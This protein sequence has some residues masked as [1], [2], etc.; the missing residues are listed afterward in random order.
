MYYILILIISL[1]IPCKSIAAVEAAADGTV[2]GNTEGLARVEALET[3]LAN[4]TI[5][6]THPRIHVTPDMVTTMRSRATG[7]NA[8]WTEIL[9][10]ASGPTNIIDAAC[11]A[12]VLEISHPSAAATHA[13]NVYDRI[14]ASAA[15]DQLSVSHW[16]LGFDWAY[17][18]LTPPQRT[19]IANKIS[20][21]MKW[22]AGTGGTAAPSTSLPTAYAWAS[23]GGKRYDETFY[24]QTWDSGQTYAWPAIALA[25]FS[26][27]EYLAANGREMGNDA[28]YIYKALWTYDSLHG[29][30]LR[31]YAYTNDYVPTEGYFI[32]AM[33]IPWFMDLRAAT[34][35]TASPIDVVYGQDGSYG[36]NVADYQLYA[37]DSDP[38]YNR[39]VFHKGHSPQGAGGVMT[40]NDTY[41]YGA[42]GTDFN[43]KLNAQHM[44][45]FLIGAQTNPYHNWMAKNALNSYSTSGGTHL[46]AYATYDETAAYKNVVDLMYKD[47]GLP[48]SDPKTATYAQLP[49]AKKFSGAKEVYMRSSFG[50]DSVIAC[51]RTSPHLT[52]TSH[53][54]WDT[55]T[56]LIY[57]KGNLAMDSGVYDDGLGEHNLQTNSIG[58]QRN[59]VAHNNILVVDP[60][61]P[62][63]PLKLPMTGYIYGTPDPGGIDRIWS[64]TF[65][66]PNLG[67]TYLH[68]AQT[69]GGS[70]PIFETREGFDHTVTTSI[71]YGSRVSEMTRAATFIRKPNDTAYFI[72]FDRI[73]A[74]SSAFNKKWLIHGVNEF[75]DLGSVAST[76]VASH[77]VNYSGN[78]FK[79]TNT[80]QRN[81]AGTA[82]NNS[83]IYGSVLLPT[84]PNLRK[85]GG[86]F[87]SGYEFWVDGSSPRNWPLELPYQATDSYG[88][89]TWFMGGPLT[90]T[91]DGLKEAG[92]W[93]LEL[94]NVSPTQRDH[95]LVVMYVG[96]DDATAAESVLLSVTEATRAVVH[97]KDATKNEI[98]ALNKGVLGTSVD[99][100][101]YSYTPTTSSTEHILTEIAAGSS[102]VVTIG[103]AE[104]SGS[105]F[106][107]SSQGVVSFSTTDSIGSA[108]LI[109]VTSLEGTGGLIN[110]HI[111]HKPGNAAVTLKAGNTPVT[112]Q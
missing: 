14:V 80:L 38:A 29:D 45:G 58:Y 9:S 69:E 2:Y 53:G 83:A 68:N 87:G 91:I 55:N 109:V 77:I 34:Y 24:K 46:F 40:Y 18:S 19:A 112:I 27:P 73:N 104:V 76:E 20:T 89:K 105:P 1:L 4:L 23:S 82:Y 3:K 30:I 28:A 106:T 93:R 85:V 95:F 97:I 17:N 64:K 16:A 98:V 51:L 60:A 86:N 6:S 15:T 11:A 103:G 107:A 25:G 7:G 62:D 10:A 81:G 70:I 75:T 48:S 41:S 66:A 72:I 100:F 101:S 63:T 88:G 90:G 44:P 56:F 92:N 61:S 39:T 21:N 96:D 36:A 33:G 31:Y 84:N 67:L 59:T 78:T 35:G 5:K 37:W 32:G 108:S 74:T 8:A 71:S 52:K 65:G 42:A 79:T 102:V 110:S 99:S 49:Y 43:W 94:T 57:R 54:S 26:T 13:T 47:D 111:T 12:M 50:T 22:W